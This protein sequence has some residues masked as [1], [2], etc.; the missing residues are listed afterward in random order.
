MLEGVEGSVT[1]GGVVGSVSRVKIKSGPNAGRFMGRFVLGDFE[2]SLP[3]T[4]F[5]QPA[6]GVRP[7]RGGGGNGAG[8]GAGAHSAAATSS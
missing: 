7:L 4:L 8:Q 6:P 2:G 3:V 1:V 5:A